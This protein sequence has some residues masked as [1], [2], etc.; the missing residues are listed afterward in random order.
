VVCPTKKYFVALYQVQQQMKINNPE[1][2][3]IA[4]I[5]FVIHFC[6]LNIQVHSVLKSLPLCTPE[7]R[8]LVTGN[9]PYEF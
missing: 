1:I 7:A 9:L 2:W 3:K 4:K 5:V 8:V 6:N